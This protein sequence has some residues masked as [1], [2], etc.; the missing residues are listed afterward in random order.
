MSGT[1]VR[2]TDAVSPPEDSDPA[3]TF[4]IGHKE[5]DEAIEMLREAAGDG[6]ITV[7][8]L[9]ERMELVQ[10]AKFPIDLDEVLSDLTTQ[11]PS[12]RYRP[13]AE[14]ARRTPPSAPAR[15]LPPHQQTRG[16]DPSDPLVVKATWESEHRR[17]RWQVPPYIRAE[18]SMSNIELNFLEADT[19]LAT[20]D[21]EVVAGMGSLIVVVPEDWAVNVEDLSKSWGSVKTLVDAVPTGRAPT[22][23]VGGS[24]GMGSFR[25][26]YANFFDRR[27]LAK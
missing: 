20:I 9:D 13:R 8:E 4:R 24:I 19:T 22:V 6:R 2:M 25:A 11:L 16:W 5:R 3:R 21:I 14:V 7:E 18:P 26:R 23:V 1:I 17:G 12:E 15:R 10:R 27:R